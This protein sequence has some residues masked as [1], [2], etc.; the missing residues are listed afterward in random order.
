[1]RR[2]RHCRVRTEAWGSPAWRQLMLPFDALMPFNQERWLFNSVM[3]NDLIAHGALKSEG[4]GVGR[5]WPACPQWQSVLAGSGCP[6]REWKGS[7]AALTQTQSPP[8]KDLSNAA[9]RRDGFLCPVLP[10]VSGV[11][12]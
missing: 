1:M 11:E 10:T 2:G 5:F 12:A 3:I 6:A 8:L 7:G 9:F 4:R